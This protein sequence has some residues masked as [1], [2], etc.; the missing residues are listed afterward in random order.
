[1]KNTNE[2]R[3]IDYRGGGTYTKGPN[4][5]ALG[6]QQ[7]VQGAPI[8]ALKTSYVTPDVVE[9][10]KYDPE[11]VYHMPTKTASVRQTQPNPTSLDTQSMGSFDDSLNGSHV[12]EGDMRIPILD[13]F[14]LLEASGM[15]FPD[16][17][18]VTKLVGRGLERVIDE[19][20]VFFTDL[21]KVD[22]SENPG[23]TLAQL[24]RLP[25][26]IEL[27]LACNQLRTL[28]PESGAPMQLPDLSGFKYL[29]RLD[30][31]Y[32]VLDSNSVQ[33]L[34]TLPAIKD[35]D[36]SGNPLVELPAFF[37]TIASLERL[38]LD[39]C[40]LENA[41]AL[42]Y[43]SR[44]PVLR[45]L[46]L[47]YNY[48]EVVPPY[49]CP[50]ANS[51]EAVEAAKKVAAASGGV[52]KPATGHP[53]S[54]RLLEFLDFSFNYIP[55]EESVFPLLDCP[56]LQALILYGN[57]LLGPSG[58]DQEQL[59]IEALTT[60]AAEKRDGYEKKYMEI[61]TEIP[62]KRVP[63]RKGEK[64]GRQACY[65]DFNVTA[66]QSK[67]ADKT[68][69]QWKEQR[70]NTL[71]AESIAK[72]RREKL[73]SDIAEMGT[74]ITASHHNDKTYQHDANQ[75]Q[76]AEEDVAA[77]IMKQVANSMDLS[78]DAE[79][80]AMRAQIRGGRTSEMYLSD[81]VG[82]GE[83]LQ[84]NDNIPTGTFKRSLGQSDALD[85]DHGS[86]TAAVRAL[87]FAVSN[88]LTDYYEVPAKGFLPPH[89]YVRPTATS[90]ARRLP[91]LA[92]A[93]AEADRKLQETDAK[94]K[95]EAAAA[96]KRV[97]KQVAPSVFSAH[98]KEP[99]GPGRNQPPWK[100]SGKATTAKLAVE[101]DKPVGSG[102]GQLVRPQ[103]ET[104]KLTSQVKRRTGPPRLTPS[105][106]E[107]N[108]ALGQIDQVL[109]QLNAATTRITNRGPAKS[110]VDANLQAMKEFA[111]PNTGIAGLVSMVNEVIDDLET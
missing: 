54:F 33:A 4:S 14:T 71:F 107:R 91:K 31:S 60:A 90:A 101:A 70:V 15:G 19:D 27:K 1:M 63:L 34:T 50:G 6:L 38:V 104:S 68:N 40:R 3:G 89:D 80:L 93:R 47:A 81:S 59:M 17:V 105:E 25:A 24:C 84:P 77:N 88:P 61:I 9:M 42:A 16:D 110:S 20:L 75:E 8:Q 28:G 87:K 2:P 106:E 13:G 43:L 65:R 7:R 22:L 92:V 52:A 83:D 37:S 82:Q 26:L 108:K 48:L 36:L 12:K 95:E 78:S 72:A 39:N 85:P 30:L 21:Q 102:S 18:R 99:I 56:R 98:N 5:Q 76:T 73:Q 29:Q 64:M 11:V 62:K 49:S 46:S 74:F 35:L 44:L 66:V 111:R 100:S 32:N 51:L 41:D 57:P 67:L 79:V 53:S 103:P 23:I 55:N 45:V 10:P 69:A 109:D 86:I 96:G 97:R 94:E 58:E